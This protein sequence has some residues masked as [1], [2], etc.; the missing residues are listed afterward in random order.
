MFSCTAQLG[1]GHRSTGQS[2]GIVVLVTVGHVGVGGGGGGRGG[3]VV[4]L[5]MTR[6]DDVVDVVVVVVVVFLAFFFFLRVVVVVAFAVVL[7]VVTR[8][9]C[10]SVRN[11]TPHPLYGQS[12]PQG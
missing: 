4:M 6:R 2:A 1:T 5:T 12:A 3:S 8:H 9:G 10:W 11:S 7:V